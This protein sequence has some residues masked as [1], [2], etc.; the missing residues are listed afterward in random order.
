M[1]K[2]ICIILLDKNNYNSKTNVG[3]TFAIHI[4]KGCFHNI[5]KNL[6]PMKRPIT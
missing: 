4:T 6:K 2:Q 5:K 1:D 3:E